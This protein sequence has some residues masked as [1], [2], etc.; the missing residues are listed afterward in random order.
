MPA[1]VPR[2]PTPLAL[3][4]IASITIISSTSTMPTRCRYVAT[5]TVL[6][7]NPHSTTQRPHPVRPPPP[8]P[9]TH[10]RRPAKRP[11]PPQDPLQAHPP[12]PLLPGAGH[13]GAGRHCRAV[14]GWHA[15]RPKHA[16]P[17][18]PAVLPGRWATAG[19][20][21]DR[22]PRVGS[23]LHLLVLFPPQ[24]RA[25]TVPGCMYQHTTDP[26]H[27]GCRPSCC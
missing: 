20:A 8:H 11:Q 10:S 19:L 21:A 12:P 23:R 16:H 9:T 24:R 25:C 2:P 26:R 14:C 22:H 17:V 6:P 13:C 4:A 15:H 5:H 7:H 1:R 18:L 27:Q 3:H